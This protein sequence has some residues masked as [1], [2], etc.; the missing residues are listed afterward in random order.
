MTFVLEVI[1][2]RADH[3][4]AKIFPIKT[5]WL[6]AGPLVDEHD[7]QPQRIPVGSDGF[8]ACHALF[9]EPVSEEALQR[10][11]DQAHRTI[12]PRDSSKRPAASA[13]SSGAADKY[14]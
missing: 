13:R 10:G 3:F 6:F 7:Q 14:Q 5:A 11:R 9:H 2:E 4:S 1:K 12:T 8:R